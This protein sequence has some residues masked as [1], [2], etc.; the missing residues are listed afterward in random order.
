M[1]A[2]WMEFRVVEV[3]NARLEVEEEEDFILVYFVGIS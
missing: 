1:F 2:D 3:V